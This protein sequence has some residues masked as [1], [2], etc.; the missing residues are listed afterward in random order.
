VRPLWTAAFVALAAV[1]PLAVAAPSL[2]GKGYLGPPDWR[3]N[4]LAAQGLVSAGLRPGDNLLVLSRGQYVY[5]LTGALPKARYFNAMHLLCRFPTPDDDPLGT[6]FAT[7]PKF[8]VMSDDGLALGCA[9][10]RQLLR[11]RDIL[12]K[13]YIHLAT[14]TGAWDHFALY[15]A[16]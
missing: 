2:I 13:D 14:V 7:R 16:R 1:Q 12:A 3:G 6:A 8:V 4:E 5:L 11:I 10:G 15:R 9:E